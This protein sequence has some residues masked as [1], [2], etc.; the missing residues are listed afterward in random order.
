M[1]NVTTRYRKDVVR[2]SI[3]KLNNL[4][5]MSPEHSEGSRAL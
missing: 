4:E 1:Y 3:A 5:I 2:K